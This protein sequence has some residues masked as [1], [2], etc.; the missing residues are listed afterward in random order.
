MKNKRVYFLTGGLLLSTILFSICGFCQ[1][2]FSFPD[3]PDENTSVESYLPIVTTFSNLQQDNLCFANPFL[4]S[5]A[6][7]EV[8]ESGEIATAYNTEPLETTIKSVPLATLPDTDVSVSDNAI[9]DNAIKDTIIKDTLTDNFE[10]EEEK[11]EETDTYEFTTVDESYFDDAVFIG[12]SRTVGIECYSGIKNA[13]FLCNSSL[14]IFDYDKSKIEYNGVKTSIR[15]V[16]KNQKFKKIYLMVGINDCTSSKFD[17]FFEKYTAVVEDIRSLQP[18]A[19]LFLEGNLSMTQA[20]SDGSGPRLNNPNLFQ[21]N[22]AI[23]SL[24]DQ[25]NIFYI[26]INE[27]S[28]CEDGVLIGTYTW[29]HVHIKAE[30]YSIWKDFLM[31]HGII[32]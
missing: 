6:T 13:T 10:D 29:D 18:D 5:P 16:L 14:T 15:E 32:T 22:E 3:F 9:E 2:N 30:Y 1:E 20:K 4:D 31:E 28:L 27:S 7:L 24:A 23:Q 11:F 17:A 25:K 19:I 12:D 26:D 8:M 21:R